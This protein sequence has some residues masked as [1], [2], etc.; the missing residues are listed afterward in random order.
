M[1]LDG[2]TIALDGGMAKYHVPK[3]YDD[4]PDDD[5]DSPYWDIPDLRKCIHSNMTSSLF[6]FPKIL[7]QG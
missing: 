5:D 7:P 2:K 1:L 4:G 6:C 3:D